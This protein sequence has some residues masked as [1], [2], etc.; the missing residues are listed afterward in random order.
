MESKARL[1]SVDRAG[2][3]FRIDQDRTL[4]LA[5]D[6]K[7]HIVDNLV[8]AARSNCL[9]TQVYQKFQDLT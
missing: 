2:A 3:R 1:D 4:A 5:V 9:S 6:V 8:L 7:N